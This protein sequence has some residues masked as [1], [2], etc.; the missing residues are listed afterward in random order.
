MRSFMVVATAVFIWSAPISADVE[1]GQ[2]AFYDGDLDLALKEFTGPAEKGDAEAQYWLGRV[3]DAKGDTD[4][5]IVWFTSAADQRHAES[6]RVLGIFY[7]EGKG[8][9]QDFAEAA[10]WYKLAADLDNVKAMRNLGVL[11]QHGRGIKQNFEEARRWYKSAAD[12]GNA[13]A[14]RNLAYMTYRGEGGEADPERAAELFAASASLGLGKAQYDLGQ[15]YYHGESVKKDY[16]KAFQ[17]F[18]DAAAEG[19]GKAQVMLGRMYA[20]GVGAARSDSQAYFWFSIARA[21]EPEETDKYLATLRERLSADERAS[22][23][24]NRGRR[25]LV[26]RGLTSVF[27]NSSRRRPSPPPGHPYQQPGLVGDDGTGWAAAVR[28]SGDGPTTP[29]GLPPLGPSGKRRNPS[30]PQIMRCADAAS[31]RRHTPGR[32]PLRRTAALRTVGSRDRDEDLLRRLGP[33]SAPMTGRHADLL[34]VGGPVLRRRG[35]SD[36]RRSR[37]EPAGT[38]R[39]PAHRH[40]KGR[41]ARLSDPRQDQEAAVRD[42]TLVAVRP[43]PS[44]PRIASGQRPRRR[45]EKQAAEAAPFAVENLPAQVRSER[46]GTAEPV[47]PVNQFVPLGDLRRLRRQVQRQRLQPGQ[48]AGDLRIR[49]RPFGVLDC[50][51]RPR[52]SVPLRRQGQDPALLQA[53]QHAQAAATR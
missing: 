39:K 28:A 48:A 27:E 47:V 18:S 42:R 4:G 14:M 12:R 40:R 45:L 21:Q 46:T 26:D 41:E 20:N 9:A 51:A 17:L 23:R 49:L 52:C 36:L 10:R 33:A 30:P 34:P 35:A 38:V 8:V 13:K 7:E 6:R 25:R 37:R 16:V 19:H 3:Y 11:Y 50:P 1:M 2:I 44:D 53:L 22:P 5:A 24:Q 31:I 29:G 43:G 15:F 32:R